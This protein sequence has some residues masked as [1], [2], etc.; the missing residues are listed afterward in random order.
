MEARALQ[1]NIDLQWQQSQWWEKQ[2]ERVLPLQCTFAPSWP[3]SIQSR[4]CGAAGAEDQG[5][6]GGG[7][8]QPTGA[9]QGCHKAT[10]HGANW[11]LLLVA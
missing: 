11:M 4:C 7:G 6:E 9:D 5:A 3:T 8:T 1:E 10:T 2:T